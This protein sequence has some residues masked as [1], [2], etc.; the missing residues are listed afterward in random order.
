M[1]LKDR[2]TQDMKDAMR[3]KDQARLVSIRMLLAAIQRREV[4]ERIVLDDA[5]V[6]T[7]IEKQIK[8]SR[9]AVEQF[10]KGGRADLADKENRD[11]AIM[12][13]YLPTPLSEAE[14][15]ALIAAVLAETG[16]TSIKDMG[17]V[18][19]GLKPKLAGRA[20]MAKVSAK[21]KD[22]LAGS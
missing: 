5:Q 12:Q 7:V 20:D 13:A 19:A 3:Q 2:I 16:A 11:I 15:D 14:I 21:V 22:R 10:V 9:E 18:V 8:Q 1:S 6:M 17:K 4:D